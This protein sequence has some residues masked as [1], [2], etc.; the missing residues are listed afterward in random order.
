MTAQKSSAADPARSAAAFNTLAAE[1]GH[2]LF[3]GMDSWL[4]AS[5][6]CQREII[7][8]LA[9]RLEKDGTV[10][11]QIASCKNLMDAMTL[12]ARWAG[13]T[14]RD[15]NDEMTRIMAIYTQPE[16]ARTQ[17]RHKRS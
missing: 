8:F 16:A 10:A 4:K 2:A 15:Y 1:N 6:E 14:V 13:E 3:V 9:H 5:A 12:Q 11:Q 17:Q 7:E